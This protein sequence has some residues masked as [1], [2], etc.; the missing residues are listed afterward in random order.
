ML[1]I[2]YLDTYCLSDLRLMI[3]MLA[4]AN[5]DRRNLSILLCT[6]Y[7][8]ALYDV[9][10]TCGAPTYFD[11]GSCFNHGKGYFFIYASRAST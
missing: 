9:A 11:F 3:S 6:A 2:A 7:V 10:P 8:L 4:I 5:I 1:A